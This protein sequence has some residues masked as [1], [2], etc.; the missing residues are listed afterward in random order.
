MLLATEGL[1]LQFS[2][3]CAVVQITAKMMQTVILAGIIAYK[4]STGD[5]AHSDPE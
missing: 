1:T 5:L 3:L 4:P 2:S